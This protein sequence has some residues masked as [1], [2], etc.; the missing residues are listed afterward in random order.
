MTWEG[1]C[2]ACALHYKA[3]HIRTH[4]VKMRVCSGGN[5]LKFICTRCEYQWCER[6]VMYEDA[7]RYAKEV[8]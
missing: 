5:D 1:C 8:K 2:K 6:T 7:E 4:G 3:D